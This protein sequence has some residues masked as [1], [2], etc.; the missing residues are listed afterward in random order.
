MMEIAPLNSEISEAP[1]NGTAYWTHAADWVRLRVALWKSATPQ[2]G[3]VLLFPGR[4]EYI[5]KYGRT[6]SDLQINGFTTLVIDWRGQGLADRA[7]DDPMKGHVD[8][9]SDYHKDV[10]AMIEAAEM[11]HLPRPWYLIGHSL[12]ACIGLRAIQEGLPVSACAFTSPMWGI[13]LP[14]VQRVAVWP[15]SWAALALGKAKA[16][17]PGTD[18][19]SYVMNTAFEY[20]R[21]TNDPE[22]Y[23]YY[24]RQ[25]KALPDYQLGGP[26]IGWLYQ[27]LKEL[28]TLSKTQSPELPC[29]TFCG[30]QD[31]VVD[32]SAINARLSKWPEAKRVV[33]PNA[34]HDI[35]SEIPKIRKDVVSK[36]CAF[37][38]EVGG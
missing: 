4:T 36:M 13:N 12:G 9:F 10:T 8:R 31:E 23:Q 35:F 7:C 22:M 5:E 21:L 34:K 30:E 32:L 26:T 27:T 37:F 2:K 11:L 14:A 17:A 29:L 16:Y 6:L 15:F 38:E 1:E 24:I 3:S 25:I 28:G 33:I 19:T 20:N 18:G